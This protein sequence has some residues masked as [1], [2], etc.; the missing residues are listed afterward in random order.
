MLL[1]KKLRIDIAILREHLELKIVSKLHCIDTICQVA[2]ALTKKGYLFERTFTYITI[3]NST[4]INSI[5]HLLSCFLEYCPN[6]T[7]NKAMEM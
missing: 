1:K 7:D 4:N 6:S 2:N 3:R 5:N